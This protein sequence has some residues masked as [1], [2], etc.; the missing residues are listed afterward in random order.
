[1][2]APRVSDLGRSHLG[3]GATSIALYGVA[4]TVTVCSG[5]ET[6]PEP[7]NPRCTVSR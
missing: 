1:M 7:L 2:T 4:L 5:D 6:T 3:I